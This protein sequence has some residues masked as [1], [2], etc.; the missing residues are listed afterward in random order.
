MVATVRMEG[1]VALSLPHYEGVGDVD[2][3]RAVEDTTV[4]LKQ[5]KRSLLRVLLEGGCGGVAEVEAAGENRNRRWQA[6]RRAASSLAGQ[7]WRRWWQPVFAA[8]RGLP[9]FSVT[10]G[11][12]KGEWRR[13]FSPEPGGAAA[14]RRAAVAA[15]WLAVVVGRLEGDGARGVA[16]IDEGLRQQRKLCFCNRCKEGLRQPAVAAV[17]PAVLLARARWEREEKRSLAR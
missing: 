13:S 6:G 3:S 4:S 15:R 9:C 17:V 5:P 7:Q 1:S 2:G 11:Q 12:S 16:A 8:A 10:R 14:G